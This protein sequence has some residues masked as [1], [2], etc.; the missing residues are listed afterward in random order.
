MGFRVLRGR[1]VVFSF[2]LAFW[3]LNSYQIGFL[4][5]FDQDFRGLTKHLR[6]PTHLW[7]GKEQY[8]GFYQAAVRSYIVVPWMIRNQTGGLANSWVNLWL[9]P[10]KETRVSRLP[11]KRCWIPQ[12]READRITTSNCRFSLWELPS[13][14]KQT[15]L[16]VSLSLEVSPS[17][18]GTEARPWTGS[19]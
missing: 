8:C 15:S 12:A 3:R 17:N 18:L 13:E 9:F 19:S 16:L 1:S 5:Q 14:S 10:S 7:A 6:L 11:T 4:A 2:P